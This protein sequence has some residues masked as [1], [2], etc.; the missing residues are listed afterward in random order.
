[1]LT[2]ASIIERE[3]QLDKDRPKVASVIYNRL[4]INMRLQLDSTV[5]YALN[6]KAKLTLDDLK[7]DNPYNTYV[8]AGVPPGPI[9]S[10]G[11][12]AI[13]AAA[14]PARRR[15]TSTTSSRTRTARSRS[16]RTTPTSW[17]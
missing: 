2:I 8:H 3:A 13:K 16:R 6:G 5:Q 7:T 11:I 10:P 9:C 14:Q 4:E 1:M 12:S 15:S 17:C